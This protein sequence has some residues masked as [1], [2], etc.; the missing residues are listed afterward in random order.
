MPHPRTALVT[1]AG[2]RIG[3]AMARALADDGYA[4]AIH[5]RRSTGEATALADAIVSRGGRAV[6]VTGDLA[7]PEDVDALLPAAA[8]ALGPIGVLVNNASVFE[9]DR[10]PD[11]TRGALEHH[12]RV[13]VATPVLLAQALARG[14]PGDAEGVVVNMIDQRVWKLTPQFVSYTLSK[15]A[16]FTAT[17]TLAQALAPRVRVMGLAPGPTLP[18]EMEGTAGFEQEV[19]GTLLGR[20]PALAEFGAALRFILATPSLTGQ[21]IVLDGGQHLGWRTPDVIG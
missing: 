18:N 15:A 5:A 13:N 19:A 16:L 7:S 11:V 8:A 1:G 20:G 3:A 4:V 9:D 6:V 17:Q 14:L 10:A 21:M 12:Y 2:R